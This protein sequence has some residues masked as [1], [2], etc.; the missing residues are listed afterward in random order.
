MSDLNIRPAH[1]EDAQAVYGLLTQFVTSYQPE[2]EALDR[3]FPKLIASK[4]LVFLVASIGDQ[5][6]GYAL[7]SI[8]L[9]LYANGP[10]LELQEL[11]VASEHRKRGIGRRLVVAALEQALSAGCAEATVPTRRARDFYVRLGF[12]ETAVYLKR[13]LKA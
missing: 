9:T 5:V 1:A 4:K 7:G 2:R 8:A 6:V 11:M 13:R 12:E 3:H 10:V